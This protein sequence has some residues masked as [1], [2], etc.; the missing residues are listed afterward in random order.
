MSFLYQI[1]ISLFGLAIKIFATFNDKSA[2]FVKGRISWRINL[3]KGLKGIQNPIW[4]HC[5]SLG[6]FEQGRPV[7][8]AL[9]NQGE[10]ILL[11]FFSPS[12]YEH[13]KD[14][15]GV[16]FVS[17]LPIDSQTNAQSFLEIVQPK[18]VIFIKYEF[19]FNY[20]IEID[21]KSIPIYLISG[22]FRENQYFFKIYGKWFAKKLQRFSYFF[23][24]NETS[25]ILLKSIGVTNIKVSGDTRFDRVIEGAENPIN[26]R[27]L[28]AFS[29]GHLTIVAGS[30]WEED[31]LLLK[32]L[33]EEKIFDG[34]L[35]IAPHDVD[36]S[37]IAQIEKTFS[38]TC[39]RYS[40]YNEENR[41]AQ[42]LIIDKIGILSNAYQYAD[43]AI[44]GGGFGKGIHNTLEAAIF[45]LPVLFGPIYANFQEAKDMVVNKSA[46]SF[47]KF[48]ELKQHIAPIIKDETLRT[49]LG[50]KNKSY[51]LSQAGAT[52]KIMAELEELM[53]F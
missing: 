7:I 49:N 2:K 44:I 32:Q 50:E 12:G 38:E 28:D 16:D 17:Y 20:I 18:A 14:Y 29:K 24:Q 47:S 39:L 27:I 37:R 13:K 30:T 23:V 36:D 22:I 51:V 52:E 5:S 26:L 41:E 11:T 4:I 15:K 42:V 48:D 31:E 53:P 21:K 6:E 46:F 45:G 3:I 34:K 8:E 40:K 43:I 1:F 19:W 33:L 25:E 10:S 9:R 35:I